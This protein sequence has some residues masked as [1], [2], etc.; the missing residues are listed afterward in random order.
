MP[1][2]TARMTYPDHYM[3]IDLRH[4]GYKAKYANEIS[5][6]NLVSYLLR[7]RARIPFKCAI[8]DDNC[9]T[10]AHQNIL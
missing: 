2:I 7:W 4:I 9:N 10:T 5:P 1:G 8:K 3:A 6:K